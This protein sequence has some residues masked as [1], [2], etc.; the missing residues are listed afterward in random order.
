VAEEIGVFAEPEVLVWP[1]SNKDKFAVIAS[2]GVF[3]FLTSQNVVDMVAQFPGKPIEAAKFIVAEAYRLWLKYDERTDDI[4]IIIMFFD[5]MTEAPRPSLVA[6]MFDVM[7]GKDPSPRGTDTATTDTDTY[8]TD[9]ATTDTDTTDTDTTD[10]DTTDTATTDTS[11]TVI[12][13]VIVTD[14]CHTALK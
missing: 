7:S 8:T 6:S 13:I 12:V 2:D 3:E 11:T 10:T 1:L 9:T 5:D 4:S 14:A